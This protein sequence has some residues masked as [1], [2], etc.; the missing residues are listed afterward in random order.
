MTV[1]RLQEQWCKKAP[2][3]HE[4]ILRYVMQPPCPSD[5]P[6]PAPANQ[7]QVH[8]SFIA[9]RWHT[10]LTFLCSLD[11]PAAGTIARRPSV[12][13]LI[14][15]LMCLLPNPRAVCAAARANKQ[16]RSRLKS[17]GML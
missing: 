16:K 9:G 5:P 6:S 14:C 13:P 17:G 15:L 2:P 12:R 11:C 8:T 10:N 1:L 3:T 7:E 4:M